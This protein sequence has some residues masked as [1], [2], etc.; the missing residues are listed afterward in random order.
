MWGY[1]G[2]MMKQNITTGQLTLITPSAT[3][4]F[5]T[6][7]RPAGSAGSSSPTYRDLPSHLASTTSTSPST[8]PTSSRPDSPSQASTPLTALSLA[9]AGS[10]SSRCAPKLGARAT[11]RVT[12]DRFWLRL[13]TL[14][15]LGFAEAYMAGECEVYRT[16]ADGELVEDMGEGLLDIFKVGLGEA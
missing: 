14:G 6:N 16:R 5:P 7:P 15:D 13:L 1:V 3:Y 10:G 2:R 4:L 9:S 11:I 8:P 12:S